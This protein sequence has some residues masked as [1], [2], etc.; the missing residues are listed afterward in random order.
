VANHL[1]GV[2]ALHGTDFFAFRHGD[3]VPSTK[4]EICGDPV[5][6]SRKEEGLAPGAE[7][8]VA[9]SAD[10]WIA[11][12]RKLLERRLRQG[13]VVIA[14]S[15]F[16]RTMETA[17][18][19][20][21]RL[22]QALGRAPAVK[23][24]WALRE[25]FFGDFEALGNSADLYEAAW[26]HDPDFDNGPKLDAAWGIET[27]WDVAERTTGVLARYRRLYQGYVVVLVSHDDALKIMEAALRGLPLSK[28][29]DPA[30]ATA[31]GDCVK[32]YRTT[33]YRSLDPLIGKAS[34]KD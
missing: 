25:R 18:V 9:D 13:K 10:Q 22:E 26:R 19:V 2:R 33:E 7:R 32:S 1:S 20:A 24:E 16:R 31:S 11:E 27:P 21:A 4:K 30:C 15:P 6:C 17:A 34:E 3:S 23:T 8:A 29:A 14:A 5:R 28:H 12:N